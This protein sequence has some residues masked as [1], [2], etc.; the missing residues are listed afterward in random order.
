MLPPPRASPALLRKAREGK[1]IKPLIH[2]RSIN[3]HLQFIYE[4][5]IEIWAKHPVN[6]DPTAAAVY[7]AVTAFIT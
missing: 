1:E 6:H 3:F 4:T 2:Y 7:P 5:N